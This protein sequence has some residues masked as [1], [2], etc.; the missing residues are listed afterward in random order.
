MRSSLP[1]HA[2]RAHMAL[3]ELSLWESPGPR[4][5]CQRLEKAVPRPRHPVPLAAAA[6]EAL[7]SQ[8]RDEEKCPPEEKGL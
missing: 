5:C 4:G 1:N 8:A 7:P 2:N 6:M 3:D